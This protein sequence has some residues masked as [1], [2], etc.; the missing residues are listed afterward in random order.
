M[1]LSKS[2]PSSSSKSSSRDCSAV[3]LRC[4]LGQFLLGVLLHLRVGL[5]GRQRLGLGH[6][7]QHLLVFEIGLD[8]LGEAP[9]SLASLV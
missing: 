2:S 3:P 1:T 5:G 8:L 7:F 9:C 4:E 6:V